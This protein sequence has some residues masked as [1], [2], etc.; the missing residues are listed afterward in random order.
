[1]TA[2]LLTLVGNI[3]IYVFIAFSPNLLCLFHNS[4]NVF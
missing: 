2:I 1:M 4:L 3:L